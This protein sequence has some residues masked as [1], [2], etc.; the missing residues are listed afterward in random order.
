MARNKV[1]GGAWQGGARRPGLLRALGINVVAKAIVHV[2]LTLVLPLVAVLLAATGF[3]AVKHVGPFAPKAPPGPSQAVVLDK[4]VT[5]SDYHAAHAVYTANFVIPN[6]SGGLLGFLFGNDIKVTA[7]GSVD[8]IDDFSKLTVSGIKLQGV[9]LSVVLPAPYLGQTVLDI[10][11]TKA[12][13]SDGILTDLGKAFSNSG[14]QQRAYAEA[15]QKIQVQAAQ[16]PQLISDGEAQTQ[17]FL[18]GLLRSVGV[19]RVNVTFQ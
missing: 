2:G 13:E 12:I 10:S 1:A 11:K 16:T 19:L 7:V 3:A 14:D 5:I 15:E 8:A 17:S 6:H 9:T 4:L 18:G